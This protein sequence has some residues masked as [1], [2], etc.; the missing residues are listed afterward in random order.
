MRRHALLFA[1]ML[2]MMLLAQGCSLRLPRVPE[3][4][5]V[6]VTTVVKSKPL[7][8]GGGESTAVTAEAF[9]PLVGKKIDP[10]TGGIIDGTEGDSVL[11]YGVSEI[12]V[13]ADLSEALELNVE[14]LYFEAGVPEG[15]NGE[16]TV[17]VE[18]SVPGGD[19]VVLVT[20]VQTGS[21]KLEVSAEDRATLSRMFES[22][23]TVDLQITA[24]GDLAGLTISNLQVQAAAVYSRRV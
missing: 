12:S 14:A 10:T 11:T 16:N 19:S 18:F 24:D 6:E 4:R 21:N 2:I 22:A 17:V 5:D 8:I 7:N 15:A 23:A 20:G 9:T 13:P 1:L 3:I